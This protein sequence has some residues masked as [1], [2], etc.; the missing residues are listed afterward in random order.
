MIQTGCRYRFRLLEAAFTAGDIALVECQDPEG[1]TVEVIC[2]VLEAIDDE[3]YYMP[4]GFML[5]ATTSD[6]IK[7][8]SAPRSLQGEMGSI[9]EYL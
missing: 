7:G 5:T 3:P 9:G 2:L 4:L 1:K 6:M 8:V